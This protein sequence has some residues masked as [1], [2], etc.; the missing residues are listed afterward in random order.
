[1]SVLG[2]RAIWRCNTRATTKKNKIVAALDAAY[3]LHIRLEW[4]AKKA[5]NVDPALS[6]LLAN[7]PTDDPK[8][9]SKIV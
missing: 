8:K 6:S 9:L 5:P 1:M 7:Y 3:E 4:E 2:P